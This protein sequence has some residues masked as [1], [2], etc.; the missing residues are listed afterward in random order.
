MVPMEDV[1]FEI[2]TE[3]SLLSF[4]EDGIPNTVDRDDP[5]HLLGDR[6]FFRTD[7][8]SDDIDS[9][10]IMTELGRNREQAKAH[11]SYRD[12]ILK[13]D[14][15]GMSVK[16]AYE[17][18]RTQIMKWK[19][20]LHRTTQ[21]AGVRLNRLLRGKDGTNFSFKEESDHSSSVY[22]TLEKCILGIS[23]GD[24]AHHIP[25]SPSCAM[26]YGP[27]VECVLGRDD[28]CDDTCASKTIQQA[29]VHGIK[30][31]K[32]KKVPHT[33][34]KHNALNKTQMNLRKD[35]YDHSPYFIFIPIM[36]EGEVRDWTTKKGQDQS[37]DALL[38]VGLGDD[39]ADYR[40]AVLGKAL[41][42]KREQKKALVLF[43]KYTKALSRLV[44]ETDFGY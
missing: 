27:V 12:D 3:L 16:P 1:E 13:D 43:E 40:S 41:C 39:N 34:L 28:S 33:G 44:Q 17:S 32:G 35:I 7:T 31:N 11:E 18:S 2:N 8:I 6:R 9:F 10:P 24:V 23:R 14:N 42:S 26:F 19:S 38:L 15:L 20:R 37:Y 30:G 5:F 21:A 29:L 25:H 36:T 22:D 4:V